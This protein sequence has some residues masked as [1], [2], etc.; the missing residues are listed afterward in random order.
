MAAVEAQTLSLHEIPPT[1]PNPTSSAVVIFLH[2][3]G[4][5]PQGF[6]PL[7]IV[8]TVRLDPALGHVKWILPAAPVMPV[9]GNMKKQMP[10]WFD[11]YTF[12]F[13]LSIP[14]PGDE[15]EAGILR[16]IA[17]I[18]ALLTE[19]VASGVAPSRIVLGGISQGAAVSMLT[20]LTTAHKVAGLIVLSGRLPLRNKIK[21][22]ASSHAS[23]IPIFW[24]HGTADPLVKYNLG[25]VCAAYL[26]TEIGVPA[27]PR[28]GAPE[29]LD[30]HTYDGLAHYIREDELVDVASWLKKTLPRTDVP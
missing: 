11:I 1:D 16:S 3:L 29:G 26:M 24:G 15:D 30:F 18:D 28:S 22:M 13:P 14:A 12:D 2:G 5:T 7:D 4:D 27:A 23:S 21:S 6:L 20:A 8:N 9:T 25:R 19:V 10:S 17:S